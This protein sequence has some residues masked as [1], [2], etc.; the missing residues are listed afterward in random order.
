M[1]SDELSEWV[2][3]EQEYGL[4]D[5]YFAVAQ[6]SK[7]VLAPWAREPVRSEDFVPYFAPPRRKQTVAEMKARFAGFGVPQTGGRV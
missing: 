5:V 2:A 6:L 4:P 1:G 7:A 3:F